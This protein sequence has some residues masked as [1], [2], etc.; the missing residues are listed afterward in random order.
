[1]WLLLKNLA[2]TVIVPGTAAVLLPWLIVSGD[3]N[4][5]PA[6]WGGLQIAAIPCAVAGALIYAR[7]VWDFAHRGRGTPA[8]IDAP[9]VLVVQGLYRYVRNPMYLGVLL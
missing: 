2:F 1:M 9:R 4:P 8:P 3:P 5:W 7:C 6:R